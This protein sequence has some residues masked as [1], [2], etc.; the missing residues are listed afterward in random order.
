M[1]L[2]DDMRGHGQRLVGALG[3]AKAGITAACDI[4]LMILK[5]A[6]PIIRNIP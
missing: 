1:S 3:K 6:L 2:V 4:R 5:P